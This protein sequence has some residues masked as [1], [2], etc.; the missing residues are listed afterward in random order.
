MSFTHFIHIVVPLF[1][2]RAISPY[3]SHVPRI[4]QYL[5][6]VLKSFISATRAPHV[7]ISLTYFTIGLI[8]IWCM[9][10]LR[11][12]QRHITPCNPLQVNRRFGPR[13]HHLQGRRINQTRN[14][15]ENTSLLATCF[16]S[17]FLFGLFFH[18][19]DE[20]SVFL[21]NVS[22]LSKD[23]KATDFGRWHN[24]LNSNKIAWILRSH[25]GD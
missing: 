14:Q 10:Y 8:S 16:H 21:R 15:R 2:H 11:L 20:G 19:E 5:S 9:Q 17:G 13:R 25:S 6:N 23:F 4:Y 12:S 24:S 1:L 7:H 22:W 3:W 18:T